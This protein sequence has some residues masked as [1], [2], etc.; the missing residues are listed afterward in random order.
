MAGF[1]HR[2][3][4]LI[5]TGLLLI[6]AACGPDW[7]EIKYPSGGYDYPTSVTDRDTSFYG[8]PLR[9]KFSR[10]DSFRQSYVYLLFQSFD[11]PNLSLK[12]MPE[13]IF[14]FS[15]GTAFGNNT[16]ITVTK[17]WLIVKRGDPDIYAEYD[18]TLAHWP[19]D[20]AEH[21][22]LLQRRYPLDEAGNKPW[23]RKLDSMVRLYPQLLDVKYYYALAERVIVKKNV[24]FTYDLRKVKITAR[25][26]RSIV[27]AINR[28]G[29]W[30]MPHL[31]DCD[32][33]VADGY[34]WTLEANTKRKYNWV[35]ASGCPNDSSAFTNACQQIVKLAGLGKEIDLPWIET[36]NAVP[37]IVQDVILEEVVPDTTKLHK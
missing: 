25:Q 12:P 10:R 1:T 17:D 6:V 20:E 37:V 21:F 19:A 34:G 22:R 29:Y 8:Y 24:P 2:L 26:F 31:V 32:A 28:S 33:A 23:K 5:T 16:I 4:L 11:E 13:D 30:S 27:D 35:S 7:S 36:G 3:A 14:R 9:D 15:Y 18:S